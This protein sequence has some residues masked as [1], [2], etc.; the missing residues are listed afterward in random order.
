MLFLIEHQR[1][2]LSTILSHLSFIDLISWKKACHLK[3]SFILSL[4]F[5]KNERE[6]EEKEEEEDILWKELI[7]RD[8][9][10]NIKWFKYCNQEETYTNYNDIITKKIFNKQCVIN[11]LPSMFL[12]NGSEEDIKKSEKIVNV[13]ICNCRDSSIF[14]LKNP[15]YSECSLYIRWK[16]IAKALYYNS[17]LTK[18]Y[19]NSN[20]IDNNDDDDKKNAKSF[21][22]NK[23]E[24]SIQEIVEKIVKIKQNSNNVTSCCKKSFYNNNNNNSNTSEKHKKSSPLTLYNT[25]HLDDINYNGHIFCN[26]STCYIDYILKNGIQC[27]NIVCTKKCEFHS[28]NVYIT[29]KTSIQNDTIL[30]VDYFVRN[31]LSSSTIINK[32]YKQF[33]LL[34]YKIDLFARYFY[35]CHPL[36][37]IASPILSLLSQKIPSYD[38]INMNNDNNNN[39]LLLQQQQNRYDTHY[40]ESIQYILEEIGKEEY[41]LRLYCS[42]N[43]RMISKDLTT[44]LKECVLYKQCHNMSQWP[45]NWFGSPLYACFLSYSLEKQQKQQKYGY[46]SLS[47]YLKDINNKFV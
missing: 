3:S 24:I 30:S 25:I 46:C 29:T 27:S 47:C 7:M 9:S 45:Y 32:I 17:V 34:L 23:N 42:L 20:N 28:S 40:I 10:F 15:N 13:Y 33:I 16:K 26:N 37:K 19:Y 14:P 8:Q 35:I 22:N 44:T 12:K 43:C 2:C 38:N 41:N 36:W 1:D 31:R 11:I 4:L 6:I 21:K 39:I 18:R 5:T